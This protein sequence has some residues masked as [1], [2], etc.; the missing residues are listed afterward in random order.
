MWTSAH[1]LEVWAGGHDLPLTDASQAVAAI[2]RLLAAHGAGR[3][4]SSRMHASQRWSPC[5][6]HSRSQRIFVGPLQLVLETGALP[7]EECAVL[8]AVAVV[9]VV[10][11]ELLKAIQHRKA[12]AS[13]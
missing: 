9:P 7:W 12:A 13:G 3:W 4:E 6:S 11:L 2:R 1:E 8:I 5:P 10:L